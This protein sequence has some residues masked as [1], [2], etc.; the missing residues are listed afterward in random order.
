MEDFIHKIDVL[1]IC[2]KVNNTHQV[3]RQNLFKMTFTQQV[4]PS[5]TYFIVDIVNGLFDNDDDF[6]DELLP[7]HGLFELISKSANHL[8][9][10]N[11]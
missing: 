3:I 8:K 9:V 7:R 10:W 6:D 2:E 1:N 5:P 11:L 4:C